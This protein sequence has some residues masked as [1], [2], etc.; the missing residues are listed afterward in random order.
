MRLCS[1]LDSLSDRFT[2]RVGSC[3]QVFFPFNRRSVNNNLYLVFSLWLVWN[4]MEVYIYTS[5]YIKKGP[6]GSIGLLHFS[7]VTKGKNGKRAQAARMV[8]TSPLDSDALVEIWLIASRRSIFV[9]EPQAGLMR[10]NF[11]PS[12]GSPR[13][14]WRKPLFALIRT[15]SSKLDTKIYCRN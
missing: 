13:R 6:V 10:L 11:R 15:H 12:L 2:S 4:S 3:F 5:R 14:P 1:H 9:F 7:S 8:L